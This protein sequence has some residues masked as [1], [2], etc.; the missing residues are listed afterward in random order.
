MNRMPLRPVPKLKGPSGA[1]LTRALPRQTGQLIASRQIVKKER[2]QT[3]TVIDEAANVEVLPA[4]SPKHTG[5]TGIN[6]GI[7][8]P[9]EK[10]SY[11]TARIDVFGYVPAI[12]T[13]E[14]MK[15]GFK[16]ISD[17]CQERLELEVDEA[18]VALGLK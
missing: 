16:R 15:S 12:P 11:M 17:L 10:G 5:V 8:I 2:D 7:T 4:D 14:G 9:G 1:G 6:L 13:N 3:E 18:K